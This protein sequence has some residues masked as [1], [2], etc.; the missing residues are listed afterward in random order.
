MLNFNSNLF[1]AFFTLYLFSL[2][3]LFGLFKIIFDILEYHYDIH[4]SLKI[5]SYKL[6][7]MN[8]FLK[9]S[10]ILLKKFR[11]VLQVILLKLSILFLI[12]P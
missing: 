1:I 10:L 7:C 8:A 5:S 12:K 9:N 3:L 11:L 6:V 2:N 4:T